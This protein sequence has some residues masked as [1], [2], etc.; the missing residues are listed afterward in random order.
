M[1][2]WVGLVAGVVVVVAAVVWPA[3]PELV[4]VDVSGDVTI[5]GAL[6]VEPAEP[7]A[8]DTVVVRATLSADRAVTLSKVVVRVADE[9]GTARDFPVLDDVRLDTTPRTVEASRRFAARGTHTYYLA[10]RRDGDW[11]S[12]PPWQRFTVR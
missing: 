10:Y 9:K 5:V 11:V 2:G 4:P 7:V 3:E 12:L 6:A 1:R 8:G